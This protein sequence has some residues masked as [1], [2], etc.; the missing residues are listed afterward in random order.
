MLFAII[1]M[2]I[3]ILVLTSLVRVSE[4]Q[5]L[6]IERLGKYSRTREA[7]IFFKIPFIETI[8]S[9]VDLRE[10]VCDFDPQ[11]V[12][13]KDNVT[14]Q[15][16]TVV[17]M[18]VTNARAFTYGVD[19]P[20]SALENLTAT[21][22]RNIIGAM[23]LDATLTSRDAINKEMLRSLKTA[24]EAWGILVKRV[25]VKNITPPP[26]VQAAMES[27]MRAERESRSAIKRAE[28]ERR[29]TVLKAQGEKDAASLNAEAMKLHLIAEAEG[30]AE[31]LRI[32]KA[33]ETEG[34]QRLLNS[35]FTKEE[36]I[37]LRGLSTFEKAA[38]GQSTKIIVP[39]DISNLSGLVTSVT[40]LREASQLTADPVVAAPA[41]KEIKDSV[42][43]KKNP[44]DD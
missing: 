36:I 34:I 27:Q 3:L 30:Q 25:E 6:I 10:R 38:D 31:A 24:T 5:A 8:R 21:T 23:E 19:N 40:T 12:I 20:I 9:K 29:A 7:G 11:P 22:L 4:A 42:S 43:W 16:D 44:Q 2:L 33:A 14:M 17:Y 32:Q 37:R 39:S 28:A 26:D 13:T 15:I 1:L 35:G 18:K 41:N